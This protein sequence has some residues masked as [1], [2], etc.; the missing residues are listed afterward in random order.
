M[1]QFR[2]RNVF[3]PVPSRRLGRSLGVDLVPSKA[4]S[5][6]CIYCQLG[7]TTNKTIERREY[8]PMSDVLME[9]EERLAAGTH[10]DYITLSGSGEPT[11]HSDIGDII[12]TIKTITDIP[13]AVLT[14]GSLLW[15]PDV[16]RE[17]S[18]ADLVIPSLDAGD[19]EAF[20]RVNR[21]HGSI[22][23]EPMIE[24]LV[25]FGQEYAG[26]IWLEVLLL[27]GITA[28][29]QEATK[30]ARQV[31]KIRADRVQI[32]TVSRP[33]ANVAAC[34]TSP[35]VLT[36]LAVL[37]GKTAE[38]IHGFSGT[39]EEHSFLAGKAGILDLV[40]GR[41]HTLDEISGVLAINRNETLKILEGMLNEGLLNSRIR[42][43]ARYFESVAL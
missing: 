13:V 16:R 7:H 27:D 14:N 34:A 26:E 39:L 18:A 38:V 12:R 33:P 6:D 31:E 21:P 19:E 30:I 43:G 2:V 17:L 35:A 20:A 9:L 25:S 41:P 22:A 40:Q 1:Q 42:R 37:F 10:A 29:K 11:L 5:Y 32:G 15:D 28:T 3:G 8:V 23:F 24:G 4:C 36:E